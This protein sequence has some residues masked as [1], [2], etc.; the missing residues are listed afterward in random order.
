[1]LVKLIIALGIIILISG[2]G[3]KIQKTSP[4]ACFTYEETLG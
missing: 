2:C 3:S 4:C 1:M